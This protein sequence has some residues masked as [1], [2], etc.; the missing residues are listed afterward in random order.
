MWIQVS[1][2]V[3]HNA[4]I[5][6]Q[7]YAIAVAGGSDLQYIYIE[8]GPCTYLRHLEICNVYTHAYRMWC[9]DI[10]EFVYIAYKATYG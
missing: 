2:V 8:W 1:D 4:T 3:V 7:Y 5:Y 10:R 9:V 6:R